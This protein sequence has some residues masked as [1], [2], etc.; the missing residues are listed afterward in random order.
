MPS[1]VCTGRVRRT[2]SA[3]CG[4]RST[5][6]PAAD[7]NVICRAMRRGRRVAAVAVAAA[8]AFPGAGADASAA[9]VPM[10][11]LDAGAVRV[12]VGADPFRLAFVDAADGAR[13]ETLAGA[14]AASPDD[15][16]ARYGSLGYAMDRRQPVVNNAYLGYYAA[17]EA[18]TLWFHATKLV[19]A[20]RETDGLK[21]VLDTNDPVGNQIEVHVAKVADGV[22]SLA[23]KVTGPL[24]GMATTSGAAFQPAGAEHYLGFGSRSNAVDQ[25]GNHVF[26]WAEEGPFS[27]GDYQK[28]TDLIPD[29]T[30][31]TGPTA[32]NFPVP[33][34]VSTRGFGVLI[35][36]TERS[37]FNLVNERPNACD[38]EVD[39]A[40]LKLQV[41]AGPKP[42][43][44]LRRYSAFSGREPK[45]APWLFG[46]WYQP[47]DEKAPLDL[48]K[49][50][51]A[52]DV[53]VTLAQT[54]T[55]YLPCGA[56]KGKEK[57]ERQRVAA[58]HALGYRITTYF[59]PH[60][61]TTYQPVYDEMAAKGYFV[62]DRSGRP[63]LLS[64]PFTADQQISEVDFTNPDAKAYFQKLLGNAVDAG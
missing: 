55:H 4:S 49:R 30:F 64:N 19:T 29:F 53:P 6:R 9:A 32:S 63:Y 40:R 28:Y 45:P 57:D 48:A 61:C 46:P 59:N 54:Y 36:Q 24:A 43:D 35:D 51:R 44:V 39:S 15:P 23:A 31:P 8:C 7:S 16:R 10:D 26:T 56:Q 14:D 18:D 13:L 22:V 60:V 27:S 2:R 33:W 3:I 34:L 52:D 1:R 58:Y 21:L 42:A 25:T 17:A 62:K 38:A 47:T 20:T 5:C 37:Y 50:F 11:G 41:F 12:E